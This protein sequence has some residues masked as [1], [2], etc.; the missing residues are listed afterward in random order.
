MIRLFTPNQDRYW[1]YSDLLKPSGVLEILPAYSIISNKMVSGLLKWSFEIQIAIFSLVIWNWTSYMKESFTV[2]SLK[3]WFQ[4]Y[5]KYPSSNNVIVIYLQV[6]IHHHY[7][8]WLHIAGLV[9]DCSIFS[10]LAVKQTTQF[11]G[12]ALQHGI[13]LIDRFI[14]WQSRST[15]ATTVNSMTS[16]SHD[17]CW[18]IWEYNCAALRIQ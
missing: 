4:T 10:V 17:M 6:S 12:Y 14:T 16:R 7:P 2:V 11:R 8:V 9:Q 13:G 18:A 5:A 15:F 1:K 3:T